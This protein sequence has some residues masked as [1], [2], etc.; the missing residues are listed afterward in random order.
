MRKIDINIPSDRIIGFTLPKDGR[1]FVCDHDEV[2]EVV[3]TPSLEVNVTDLQPY[4]VAE[5]SDFLGLGGKNSAA[6][7]RSTNCEI[8]YDFNPREDAVKVL[9]TSNGKN[10][11]IEFKTFSGDW[12]SASLSVEG[13]LFVL[14]EPYL[15]E[16]Y[17]V[18]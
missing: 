8:S 9:Y 6:I 12:F 1:F 13:D 2:W 11:A 4:V 18:Q 14:A 3:A 17:E 7:L 10:G 16:L 5:R 15:L